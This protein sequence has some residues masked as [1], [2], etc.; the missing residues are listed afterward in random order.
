MHVVRIV[1]EA[2]KTSAVGRGDIAIDDFELLLHKTCAGADVTTPEPELTTTPTQVGATHV[3]CLRTK[4]S[5]LLFD[6]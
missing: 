3:F 2:T 1:I 4:T 6:P 5:L